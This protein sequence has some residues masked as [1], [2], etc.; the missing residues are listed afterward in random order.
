MNQL[1]DKILSLLPGSTISDHKKTMIGIL[2][3]AMNEVQ[4]KD[5]FEGLK[6]EKEKMAGLDEKEKRIELKYKI[7]LDKAGKRDHSTMA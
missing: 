5:L 3:D 7:L 1:K 6:D 4:L 2:I